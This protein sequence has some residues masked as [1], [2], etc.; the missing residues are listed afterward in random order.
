[1]M[2]NRTSMFKLILFFFFLMKLGFILD[3]VFFFFCLFINYF[4]S[5]GR[6]YK[7]L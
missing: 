2:G 4:I 1:M 6:F 3:G 5:F 7:L